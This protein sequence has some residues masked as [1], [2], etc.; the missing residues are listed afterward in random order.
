[1]NEAGEMEITFYTFLFLNYIFF[2]PLSHGRSVGHPAA[3][4]VSPAI[5]CHSSCFPRTITRPIHH[6]ILH[7]P[8]WDP[9]VTSRAGHPSSSNSGHGQRSP[10]RQEARLSPGH[11]LLTHHNPIPLRSSQY[12]TRSTEYHST[13]ILSL[14]PTDNYSVQV[15]LPL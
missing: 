5:G 9:S 6:I 1:M 12:L 3:A 2:P 13:R 10:I 14:L 7:H 15:N 11:W 8:L 4:W